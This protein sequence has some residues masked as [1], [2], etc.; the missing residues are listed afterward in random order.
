M[1]Q[2]VAK[3]FA[4]KPQEQFAKG[5]ILISADNTVPDVL[6]IESG[7][8]QQYTNKDDG[9]KVVLM[10]FKAGAFFPMS[11]ALNS[12]PNSKYYFEAL[13]PCVVRRA[14]PAQAVEFLQAHPDVTLDLLQR[15]YRGTDGLLAKLADLMGA[16]A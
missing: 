6:Y 4:T 2:V 11:A 15:V 3:F 16:K 8:V 14:T 5:D 12:V 10:P 1:Q 7:S 9:G 13:E